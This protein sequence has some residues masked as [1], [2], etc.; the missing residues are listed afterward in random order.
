MPENTGIRGNHSLKRRRLGGGNASVSV[1]SHTHMNPQFL[2]FDRYYETGNYGLLHDM[3]SDK[4]ANKQRELTASNLARLV[5][6][7][8][9]EHG[10]LDLLVLAL[11]LLG[12]GVGLL[13][14]LLTSTKKSKGEVQGALLGKLLKQLM[15]LE[16]VARDQKALLIGANSCTK[17]RLTW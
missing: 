3:H 4:A 14:T 12:L 15:I 5:N 9:L 17:T 2:T 8:V 10:E 13:L 1:A 16:L 11:D 6:T 7:V